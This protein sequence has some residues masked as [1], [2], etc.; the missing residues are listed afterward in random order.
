MRCT[1][2]G[3][4][5]LLLI[6]AAA[7]ASAQTQPATIPTVVAQAMALEPDMLGRPQYFDGRTPPNWPNTLLPPDVRVIGGGTLGDSAMFRI[8]TA[9]FEFSSQAN[10]DRLLAAMLTRAGYTRT[11]LESARTS[12]G[13][14]VGTAARTAPPSY[15]KGASMVTFGPVDSVRAPL[16]IAVHLLDGEIGRQ[17]CTPRRDRMAAGH[18]PITVPSLSAPSGTIQSGV[19][20][21]WSD[22]RGDMTSSLRTTMPSDSVLSHYT[23]Q[24]VA[25]GWTS[26]GR[27]LASDGIGIQ[28]FTFTQ[29][30]ETWTAA[31]IVMTVGDRRE[32][33]LHFVKAP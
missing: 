4:V 16:V 24:L 23:T 6:V 5:V 33:L 25:A 15:C 11:D 28:R 22:S 10:P 26:Q 29:A 17:N 27:T 1:A 7:Q 14:F 21:S 3:G 13:G 8:E 20:S 31:L 19:G 18:F 32:M 12:G 2:R 9:V 30:Q